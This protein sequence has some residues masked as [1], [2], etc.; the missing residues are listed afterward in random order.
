MSK[1]PM[2]LRDEFVLRRD[3]RIMP[4]FTYAISRSLQGLKEAQWNSGV[5]TENSGIS[6]L[7]RQIDIMVSYLQNVRTYPLDT[8]LANSEA[9]IR[10]WDVR[11]ALKYLKSAMRSFCIVPPPNFDEFQDPRLKWI[12]MQIAG[13][14]WKCEAT[15]KP[16]DR[17]RASDNVSGGRLQVTSVGGFYTSYN[18]R[19][20]IQCDH[21][22]DSSLRDK[23][24]TE[25]YRVDIRVWCN[26]IV[27]ELGE[28]IRR[29]RSPEAISNL[30]ESSLLSLATDETK[31]N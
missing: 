1:H 20:G 18:A 30:V 26:R 12:V 9:Q 8:G 2:T 29:T 13:C 28:E 11:D 22:K 4:I 7:Y 23:L 25:H 31:E 3:L 27:K 6:V 10:H 14:V 17:L 15:K 24:S 19:A 21:C 16:W 5:Y